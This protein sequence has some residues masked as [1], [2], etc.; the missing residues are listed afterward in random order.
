MRSTEV[1]DVGTGEQVATLADEESYFV[2]FSPDGK[3]L[4]TGGGFD[5]EGARLWDPATGERIAILL[6]HA[7][8]IES[9]A[10]SPDGGLVVTAGDGDETARIW[11]LETPTSILV[12][13]HEG[14][15]L[16]ADFSPN[17]RFVVT[18]TG[19]GT[20]QVWEVASGESLGLF[21][22]DGFLFGVAFSPDGTHIVAS[23]DQS[24]IFECD[25]CGSLQELISLARERV[26]RS[27]TPAERR[28]YLPSPG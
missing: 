5:R 4:L 2:A 22:A 3:T 11:D 10:F 12:L 14:N 23:D 7:D 17:G 9:A 24:R 19:G 26:T 18:A 28:T 20:V 25:V 13:R 27:L 6:G 16:A 8:P 21:R 1:W 15:V